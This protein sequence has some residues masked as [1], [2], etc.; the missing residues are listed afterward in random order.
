PVQHHRRAAPRAE[1]D[2]QALDLQQRLAHQ[3]SLSFGFSASLSPSP[4]RLTASTVTKI[5][6]PGNVTA[7][8]L[9]STY[10]RLEPIISPQLIWF[11]SPRPRN[12]SP[13]SNRIAEPTASVAD[14]TSG[15]NALGRITFQMILPSPA[16]IA[17]SARTNSRL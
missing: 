9:V 10:C 17:R 6:A 11:G 8:Q 14:T 16:P 13:A 15:G 1:L 3:R 2:P 5:A 12:D 4:I 7:H